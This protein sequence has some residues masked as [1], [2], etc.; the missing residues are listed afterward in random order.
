MQSQLAAKTRGKHGNIEID[1]CH[2][3]FLLHRPPTESI[4]LLSL[5]ELCVVGEIFQLTVEHFERLDAMFEAAGRQLCLVLLGDPMQLP[6]V[7]GEPPD[8]SS[9]W[10]LCRKI[11]LPQVHRCED[12]V[13]GNKLDSLR[14][15]DHTGQ[16][17][18]AFVAHLCR[19]HKAG[20]GHHEPT[21]LD[22]QKVLEEHP[23]TTFITCTRRG[24]AIINQHAVQVLFEEQGKRSVAEI[25]ADYEDN[26]ENFD[27]KSKVRQDRAPLANKIALYKG[28]RVILTKNLDKPKHFVNGMTCRVISYDAKSKA[29]IVETQT[30]QKLA[31]YPYTDTDVPIKAISYQ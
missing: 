9:K 30:K 19:G 8:N 22:V 18:K 23:K 4:A 7:E 25:A 26:Q 10:K 5:Y 31:I 27:A 2:G 1:T 12:P 24:A 6:N 13:L 29:I 21:A 16:V 11:A 28:L 20:S 15:N 3:A 17:G 14:M